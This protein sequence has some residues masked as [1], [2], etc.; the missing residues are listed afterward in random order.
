MTAEPIS[1]AR[2]TAVEFHLLGPLAV[3]GIV[4]P[5]ARMIRRLLVLLALHAGKHLSTLEISRE[6]WPDEEPGHRPS[7]IQT[8]VMHLRRTI[9][10]DRI[11]TRP[12]GYW[13]VI[14]PG[15]VDA[16]RFLRLIDQARREHASGDGMAQDTL[17]AA[18]SLWSGPALEDVDCGPVLAGWRDR[19][20]DAHRSAR[21]LGWRIAL[22][23]GRHRDV[24]DEL[25]V[26]WRQEPTR[27][28]TAALFML[29]LFRC[30]MR[31]SALDVYTQTREA[32]SEG[33]GLDPG[34]GLVE[35][36]RQ[37]LDGVEAK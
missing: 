35:M 7:S 10:K 9:G 20:G 3:E 2:P 33:Y 5:S 23:T 26:A 29:A 18:L 1:L 30:D 24:V 14:D 17:R 28:D 11:V 37:I 4:A 15:S 32:L 19:L 8:Y 27:E 12:V 36:Q 25:G 13:S 21:E 22:A 31:V 6:L 34:S 16:L